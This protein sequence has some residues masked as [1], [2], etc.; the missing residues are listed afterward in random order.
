[1]QSADTG[2]LQQI[3]SADVGLLQLTYFVEEGHK[4]KIILIVTIQ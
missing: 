2:L 1:M 4:I 3:Q